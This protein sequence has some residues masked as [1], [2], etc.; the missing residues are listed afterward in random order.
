MRP[1][2]DALLPAVAPLPQSS[3]P[4]SPL[5]HVQQCTGSFQVVC[6]FDLH[7]VCKDPKCEMQHKSSYLFEGP[8]ETDGHRLVPAIAGRCFGD[9]LLDKQKVY[10]KV[11]EFVERFTASQSSKSVDEIAVQLVKLVRHGRSAEPAGRAGRP[12]Y[13]HRASFDVKPLQIRF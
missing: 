8:G 6:Y 9:E 1:D 4:L 10:E 12:D 7:G 11:E 3:K 2:G 5:Q 13:T